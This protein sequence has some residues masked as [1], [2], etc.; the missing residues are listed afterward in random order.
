MSCPRRNLR[1]YLRDRP[2]FSAILRNV[3][4]V[5]EGG[6]DAQTRKNRCRRFSAARDPSR[7]RPVSCILRRGQPSVLPRLP[8]RGGADPL[9][10]AHTIYPELAPSEEARRRAYCRLFD[11]E[12]SADTLQRLRECT[13]VV[14]Y[15]AALGS[16][17]KL[18]RWS[19]DEPGKA[20]SGRPK[21]QEVGEEHQQ[22]PL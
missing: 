6:V 12:L 17:N 2:R 22:I 15:S 5:P 18:R 7:H 14:S 10:T 3:P 13:K 20:H 21:K 11:D 4:E 19:V 9:V 1:G 16:R 8:S